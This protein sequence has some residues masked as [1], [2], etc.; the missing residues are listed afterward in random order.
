MKKVIQRF[1]DTSDDSMP[2]SFQHGCLKNMPLPADMFTQSS[3]EKTPCW[4]LA[5]QDFRKQWCLQTQVGGTCSFHRS[6]C[7]WGWV[8][9][10]TWVP[11]IPSCPW[12][13]RLMLPHFASEQNK[14]HSQDFVLGPMIAL[15]CPLPSVT[16]AASSFHLVGRKNHHYYSLEFI[17]IATSTTPLMFL[18]QWW[19]GTGRTR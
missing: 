7:P 17:S 14:P 8:R 16:N 9:F 2:Q 13:K 18:W 5:G 12:L 3:D 4:M 6:L 1:Y 15:S 11:A 10:V 19:R